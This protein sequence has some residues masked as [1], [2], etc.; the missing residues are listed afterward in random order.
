M[1]TASK[2]MARTDSKHRPEDAAMEDSCEAIG[3]VAAAYSEKERDLPFVCVW[4][5]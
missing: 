2:D 3:A 1:V 5:R 4:P